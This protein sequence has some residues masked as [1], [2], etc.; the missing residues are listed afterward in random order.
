M[1]HKRKA[2]ILMP[3]YA[4]PSPGGIGT[5]GRAAYQWIDF[6][7]D[8]RIGV[9]QMLPVGPTGFGNSPYQSCSAF[10][11]NEYLIDLDMLANEGLLKAE[12]YEHLDFGRDPRRVD[13]GKLY[14]KRLSALRLAFGRFR[15]ER[16]ADYEA[17]AADGEMRDYALFCALKE[18]FSMRCWADWPEPY[19]DRDEGALARFYAE[20]RDAVDFRLFLQ[21]VFF[22]QYRLLKLYAKEAGVEL[23]GDMPLYVSYDSVD[24]WKRRSAF[25]LEKDG[26]PS[27]AAGVPPDAFSADGQLWGNPLFDWDAMRADGYA[28]WKERIA[29]AFRLYDILRIDH[30]RGFDRYYAVPYGENSAKRGTW[31]QG[32]GAAFFDGLKESS[33][34]A[35]DLGIIDEGVRQ[36]LA[37]MGYPG[38]KVLSFA[39]DDNPDNPYLPSRFGENAAVYT[40]THDNPPVK[41]W[42]MGQSREERS[43]LTAILKRECRALSLPMRAETPDSLTDKLIEVAFASR[44]ALAVIPY[45]DLLKLG[46]EGRINAPSTLSD[47]NW[48]YRCLKSDFTGALQRRLSSLAMRFGRG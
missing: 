4:L 6:L 36:L 2:G 19:R 44:A 22:S 5:L 40:G 14:E 26:T 24:V 46:E 32:P 37:E 10:A 31:R 8:A 42:L 30:F 18:R 34:V 33:I 15:P 7:R 35:E 41:A 23:F 38:M 43:R 16:Y 20:H 28:W 27:A 21:F 1:F 12:E 45:C 47:R 29:R 39:F 11:G 17:F 3:V 9:W 25:L 48:S 13:Y